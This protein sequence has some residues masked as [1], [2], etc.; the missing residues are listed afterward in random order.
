MKI[1][2]LIA[3]LLLGLMF[4][5]FGANGFLHFIPAVMPPGQAA[6]FFT[7][8]FETH[9]AVLVFAVQLI[10]GLMLLSNQYVPLALVALAAVIANIFTFHITMQPAGLIPMPIV[11]LVCWVVV[12]WDY[13]S[14]F[15]PMLA[16][17]AP[18]DIT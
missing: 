18:T 8:L 10:A 5:V 2:V 15:A 9:Y 3:R 7:V 16:R 13:R 14:A 1:V 12:A 11:A 4:T 6:T 17:N